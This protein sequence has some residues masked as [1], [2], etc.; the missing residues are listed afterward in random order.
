M[1]LK[2]WKTQHERMNARTREPCM[3]AN[4]TQT[5]DIACCVFYVDWAMVFH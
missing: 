5:N 4:K 1:Q 2:E 3:I